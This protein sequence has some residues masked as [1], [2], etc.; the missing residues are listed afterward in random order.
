MI[1]PKLIETNKIKLSAE[2]QKLEKLLSRI[3]IKDKQVGDFHASFSD[4][5]NQPD[6]N[7]FE[8]AEYETKIAQGW[9]MEKHLRNIQSALERIEN[10]TYGVCK[11]G[12]ED[13]DEARLIV[14]PE[15]ENCVE[16]DS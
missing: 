3:A 2:K 10:H 9:D 5:G 4:V 11:T 6:E 16:H 14:V 13:I 15:A 12:G 1:D 8:V 7:A